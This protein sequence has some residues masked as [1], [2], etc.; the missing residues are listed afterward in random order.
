[1]KTRVRVDGR[2]CA[3]LA[4]DDRGLLYGDGLFETLRVRHGRCPLWREHLRRLQEGCRRL[5]L[6]TPDPRWLADERDRLIRGAADAVLRIT[7][8]RGSGARGYAPPRP[9]HPRGVLGLAPAP[10]VPA[11]WYRRGIRVRFC[12]LRVARQPRLAGLKHLNR[13]EQVLA[14]AEWCDPAIAEGLMLDTTGL[15]IGA[16]AA[17][18]FAV[19]DGR[20]LT[21]RVDRAGVAG[22]GRALV[23]RDVAE[24]RERTLPAAVLAQASELILVSAVRGALPVRRL[25]DH[26]LRVGPWARRLQ[27]L[28]AAVGIGGADA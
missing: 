13:L 24:A 5:H 9:A 12:D 8:T 28:F 14:R 26:R 2:T 15:V 11:H 1:M 17:N 25:Q 4:A 7:W 6:P 3:T 19:L 22:V 27:E 23:L 21:P 18:L 10:R 20:L 16:T